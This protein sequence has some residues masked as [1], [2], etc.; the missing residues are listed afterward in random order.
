MAL[1][2][3]LLNTR[4]HSNAPPFA[5]AFDIDGVLLRE[6]RPIPGAAETL[7]YL[8]KHSIPFILLTN[9]GGKQERERVHDL[10]SKLKVELTVDNFV[11]S[12]T[13]FQELAS[14][15]QDKNILVTGSDAA[16]IREI[17]EEYG[18]RRVIIPADI[19]MGNPTIWPFEP[20]MDSVYAATARNLPEKNPKIEGIFVYNDPRDWALDIQ[21]ISDLLMSESGIL[22]TYSSKNGRK[23]LA[24]NGWQSDN[25]P[26]IFFSNPDLFWSTAYHQPRFGQG[27]FQGALYGVWKEVTGQDLKCNIIGKPHK[28]TYQYAERVLQGHRWAILNQEA[29]TDTSRLQRVYMIGDNPESDIRGANEYRSTQGTSWKSV[30][31]KTGLA[32]ISG[33]STIESAKKTAAK[34]AVDE[35]L[36]PNYKLV[37]IGSGSTVVYVVEAIANW[38]RSVTDRMAFF[39]TGDQSMLLIQAAGLRLGS[40]SQLVGGVQLD[41]S[42]DGADE[43]DEDLNLIKGGGACLLQEKIVAAASRRFICVADYRKMSERLCTNW[44][45]GIPIEVLPLAATLILD[46]L[47]RLGSID[48]VI[49]QGGSQ[50]AGPVV[51]DNGMWIID[52]PFPPLGAKSNSLGETWTASGL[53]E[54]LITIPG[55]IETG[56]FTGN[57]GNEAPRGAQK[58]VA[59]YF[60]MEDGTVKTIGS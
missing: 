23:D 48:P 26:P 10:T 50:K 7:E 12:H 27:A 38:D 21:L 46:E 33:L 49:R 52:A 58:P 51:T 42:F 5:F 39:P 44:K 35:Y 13:P 15:L 28:Y 4:T 22:G 36:S 24:N 57:N 16:K 18:F 60:G 56:L 41:V 32:T 11:Q 9:G 29:G 59:A 54:R 8:Q 25:Q 14:E 31:V 3:R 6:S 47:R 37:G 19:L 17:A 20:L 1:N 55:I 40:L 53:A 45:K 34:R 43:I 30:L 2:K